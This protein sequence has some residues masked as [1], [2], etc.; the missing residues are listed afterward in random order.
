MRSLAALLALALPAAAWADMPP[1]PG[2]DCA[3]GG[4]A[5]PLL[6]VL[7]AAVAIRRARATHGDAPRD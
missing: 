6:A 3:T 1:G 7:V 4:F 2:C 5:A